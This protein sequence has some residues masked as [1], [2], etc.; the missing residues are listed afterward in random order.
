M[1][2]H[3][4]IIHIIYRHVQIY[5]KCNFDPP[6]NAFWLYVIQEEKDTD[7]MVIFFVSD[8]VGIIR[9]ISRNEFS[10]AVFNRDWNVLLENIT[11]LSECVKSQ[12][13]YIRVFIRSRQPANSGGYF[14]YQRRLLL[15]TF[16]IRTL[17][18]YFF[19]LKAFNIALKL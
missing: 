6:Y 3:I 14:R 13:D 11:W 8:T 17:K 1:E 2:K 19:I 10:S 12:F 7:I 18:V 9:K 16:A 4:H 5:K 15:L